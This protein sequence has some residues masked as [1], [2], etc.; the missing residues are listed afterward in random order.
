M[1]QY[2]FVSTE[3]SRA[4]VFGSLEIGKRGHVAVGRTEIEPGEFETRIPHRQDLYS[5]DDRAIFCF[6]A[7]SQATILDDALNGYLTGGI[8][9]CPKTLRI[10]F[11]TFDLLR[12]TILDV[13]AEATSV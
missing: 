13:S 4:V 3:S 12:T 6:Y 8:S 1:I 9:T 2:V 7:S 11:S 10:H 5:H